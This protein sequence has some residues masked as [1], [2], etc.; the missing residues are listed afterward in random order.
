L[1]PGDA[2]YLEA[3]CAFE[4]EAGLE[5]LAVETPLADPMYD[6]AGTPDRIGYVAALPFTSARSRR[7]VASSTPGERTRRYL[8]IVDYKTGPP[9]PSYALQLG[10]YEHL[11][12]VNAVGGSAAAGYPIVPMGVYLRPDGTFT[13]RIYASRVREFLILA[14]AAAILDAA[15]N[16]GFA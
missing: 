6:L 7:L 8:A 14:S 16:G 15:Q 10:G 1:L 13:P 12:R 5:P 3:L 2:G 4:R 9:A 11:A